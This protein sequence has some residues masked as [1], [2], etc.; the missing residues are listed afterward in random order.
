VPASKHKALSSNPRTDKKKKKKR[1][2]IWTQT[3]TC[4]QGE[5]HQVKMK[6]AFGVRLY[7]PRTPNTASK[8]PETR[9]RFFLLA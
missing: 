3:C 8:T 2:Q 9:S 5:H 1:R 4:T 7:K 6:V